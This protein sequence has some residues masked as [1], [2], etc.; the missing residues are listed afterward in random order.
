MIHEYT[1]KTADPQRQL[2]DKHGQPLRFMRYVFAESVMKSRAGLFVHAQAGPEPL[3]DDVDLVVCATGI[4]WETSLTPLAAE[5]PTTTPRDPA[6]A[7]SPPPPPATPTPTPDP[8]ARLSPSTPTEHPA[9]AVS[10]PAC[11]QPSGSHCVTKAG[12]PTA[13][14]KLRITHANAPVA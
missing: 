1:L 5:P 14:H 12:K 13:P 11:H 6:Q 3:P 4:N 8:P 9:T 7:T 2:V 10:C